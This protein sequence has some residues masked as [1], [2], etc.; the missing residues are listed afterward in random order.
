LH[1]IR[2]NNQPET[3]EKGVRRQ[4][5]GVRSQEPGDAR[6]ARSGRGALWAP[7]LE[8]SDKQP[9]G[10]AEPSPT[11]VGYGP[12]QALRI[13]RGK[14]LVTVNAACIAIWG[15]THDAGRRAVIQ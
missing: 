14:V 9:H 5:P 15:D 3:K 8:K 6:G 12:P 13:I 11:M 4:K 7:E 1:L 10:R 2:L